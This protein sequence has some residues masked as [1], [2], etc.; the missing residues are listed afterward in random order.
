MSP[1]WRSPILA[2]RYNEII[3]LSFLATLCSLV[4]ALSPPWHD[5]RT[6]HSWP[7][8]PHEWEWVGHPPNGTTINL[9]VA[10]K[11]HRENALIDALYEVSTPEHPKYGQHLSKEQVAELVAPHP[12]TLNFVHSWLDYNG[13]PSSSISLTLGGNTLKLTGVSLSRANDLLGASYQVY[14]HVTT[15]ETVV[16]T[17]GYALPAALHEL[18]QTVVPTT[19]FDSPRTGRQKSRK[20]FDGADVRPV[21][22]ATGEPVTGSSRRDVVDVT[23]PSFLRELYSTW[24]YSPTATGNILGIVGFSWEY[25]SRPDLRLFMQNYR[26]DGAYATFSVVQVNDGLYD[27]SDPGMEANLD[28]QY[29]QGIAYPIRHI[30]Y[31]TGRGP[32]GTDEWFLSFLEGVIGAPVLPQTLSLSYGKNETMIPPEY[33]VHVC[34]LFAQLGTRGV[35]VLQATGDNGVGRGNCRDSAG[36]VRFIPTFPATCPYVTAVGGTMNYRPEIAA[37]ISGGGFSNIFL[38][39]PYQQQDVSTFL[40]NFGSNYQ[41]LYNPIGRAIPDISAQAAGFK[42]FLNGQEFARAGTSGSAPIVAGMISLLNDNRISQGKAPRGFLNPWL[43]WSKARVGFTDI[44]EG[45]NPGCGTP[46]FPAIV[47]W[48][49]V[50]GLGTPD[51]QQLLYIDDLAGQ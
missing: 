33:A 29:A 21:D 9:Y 19:S 39:Q 35:S 34:T 28:M 26:S 51:F 48:D 27:P 50:T 18:V 16:R 25:P 4:T 30:F 46:G 22:V 17:T 41:G 15:N 12:D 1:S 6:K 40:R 44:V 24:V 36:N 47:G 13:I 32:S 5:I 10:L 11:S 45:S 43:Y 3:V 23:T 31:S 20:I 42:V 38:R 2:M 7:T 37:P 49:P 14:R 8:V